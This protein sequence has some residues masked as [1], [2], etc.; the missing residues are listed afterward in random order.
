[1]APAP[2]LARHDPTVEP[3]AVVVQATDRS[4][5]PGSLWL[6]AD[7]WSSRGEGFSYRDPRG[8]IRHVDLEAD[9]SL[10]VAGSGADFA[11]APPEAGL[12]LQLLI[13]ADVFC[14]VF[15][16]ETGA[17]TGDGNYC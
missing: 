13:G 11:W 5:G 16:E 12:E 6:D 17:K 2:D 1:M 8:A 14:A 7:R 10:R 9:S 15:A 4:G 3:T